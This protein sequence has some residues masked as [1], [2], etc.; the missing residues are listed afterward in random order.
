M[1][2]KHYRRNRV[3]RNFEEQEQLGMRREN[4]GNNQK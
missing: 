4:L 2:M 3:D 1:L